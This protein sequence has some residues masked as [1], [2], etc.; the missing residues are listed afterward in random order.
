[1]SMYERSVTCSQH[2]TDKYI[3]TMYDLRLSGKIGIGG[4]V[5]EY[6]NANESSPD[7]SE[8]YLSI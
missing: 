5:D 3:N 8:H 2:D 4:S 7:L 6:T 1:M